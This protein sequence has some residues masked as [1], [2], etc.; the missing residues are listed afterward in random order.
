[1]KKTFHYILL[2]ILLTV[3]FIATFYSKVIVSPNSYVFCADND[4]GL[5]NYY[6]Y[7]CFIKNNKSAFEFE[8]MNYPYYENFLYTDGQPAE[9]GFLR[10]VK[11]LI[12]AIA[13]YSVGII[14][15]FMILSFVLTTL[16]L[17]L[18]FTKLKVDKLLSVFGALAITILSPQVFRLTGHLALSYSF[19]IPLTIYLL[20]LLEEESNFKRM[21]ILAFTLL[22]FFFTHAYLGMIAS[23]MVI[24]YAGIGIL[25]NLIKSDKADLIRQLKIL[26]TSIIPFLFFFI[27][28]QLTDHHPGRTTNPWGI[29]ENHAEVSTVFLPTSGPVNYLKFLVLGD[30]H[31]NWEGWAYVGLTAMSGLLMYLIGFVMKNKL[32]SKWS[33]NA[34]F[35]KILIAATLLLFLSMLLPFRDL[36]F[37]VVDK[38]DFI[39]QFR[40]IGRFAWVFFFIANI[41]AIYIVNSIISRLRELKKVWIATA[42]LVVIPI[43]ITAEGI[44]YHQNASALLTKSPNLFSL[45]Q[46]SGEFKEVFSAIH[47]NRYQAIISLP[48]FHIGSENFGKMADN[49]T[50]KRSF[51]FSYHLGLPMMNCYMTRTSIPESKHI[52][53]ALGSNF[54]EKPIGKSLKSDKPFLVV[55]ANSGLTK[56]ETR[57]LSKSHLLVSR[58]GYSL[59]ELEKDSL[60]RNTAPEEYQK[61]LLRKDRL[62]KKDEFLVS[63]TSL[64]F[65]Y[66]DFSGFSSCPGKK[67]DECYAGEQ[68]SYHILHTFPGVDLDTTKEYIARFW[69]YNGGKN[70]GQDIMK[71]MMFFTKTLENQEKWLFPV[72]DIRSTHEINGNWSMM[73]ITLSDIDPDAEYNLIVKGTEQTKLLFHIDDVLIYDQDLDIY[74]QYSENGSTYL[75]HNDHRIRV[76]DSN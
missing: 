23:A 58:A 33:G 38:L 67:Q 70:F 30:V 5:K 68:P 40:A 18:I 1:M 22:F 15:L 51:M 11:Y 10:L 20:I 42:L 9:A 44:R 29:H 35:M 63:D 53:Q 14:N 73:E 48:F 57:L 49:E 65:A 34:F 26:G 7:V 39:K 59:Y 71:G 17:Y 61:F 27:F 12:P 55:T 56:A 19:F 21:L 69:I 32:T 36:W 72:S 52:M 62:F 66:K 8:G 75:F 74:R 28:L 24:V 76:P 50:Y 16:F 41:L 6:T 37:K 64:F 60:F 46:T 45:K 3:I 25:F 13:D 4:D 54:Y 2:L 43:L 47:Q 31:Q